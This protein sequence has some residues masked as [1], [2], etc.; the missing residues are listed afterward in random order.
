MF[1]F[2]CPK[3]GKAAKY[4]KVKATEHRVKCPNGNSTPV[5][6]RGS[7]EEAQAAWN[8]YVTGATLAKPV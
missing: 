3:C 1:L 4:T 7:P 2:N 5:I 6:T 8:Q